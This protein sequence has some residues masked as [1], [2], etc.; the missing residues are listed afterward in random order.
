MPRGRSAQRAQRLSDT[1]SLAK[2]AFKAQQAGGL[3]GDRAYDEQ[4]CRTKHKLGT[5]YAGV[6]EPTLAAISSSPV[7]AGLELE[8]LMSA[9][10]ASL[11]LPALMVG[12]TTNSKSSRVVS[13]AT[14]ARLK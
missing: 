10:T 9:S 4:V 2:M 5:G 7:A 1:L 3:R 12:S 14:P 8:T 11:M 13:V 6:Q